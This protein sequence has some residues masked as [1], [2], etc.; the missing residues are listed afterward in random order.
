MAYRAFAKIWTKL[1]THP[2]QL[3]VPIVPIE[4]CDWRAAPSIQRYLL[5]LK[6]D[7]SATNS[8]GVCA[9]NAPEILSVAGPNCGVPG[10][11]YSHRQETK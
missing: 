10:L 4:K 9:G 5:S 6:P 3:R 8:P 11:R 1:K 2:D 7:L